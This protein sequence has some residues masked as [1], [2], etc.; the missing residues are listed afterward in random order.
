MLE[1]NT[2]YFIEE[3]NFEMVKSIYTNLYKKWKVVVLDSVSKLTVK[4]T[5][6]NK[7]KVS[8]YIKSLD[9]LK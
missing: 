1:I 8:L 2:D 9:L 3:E 5:K 7:K 4:I 6:I